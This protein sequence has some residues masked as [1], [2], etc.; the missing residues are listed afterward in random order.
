LTADQASK[1]H[2]KFQEIDVDGSGVID[3][4]EFFAFLSMEKTPFGVQ[5]FS[6]IDENG[7]GEIDFNEFLVGLWNMCTF[8]EE[9]L[10][11]FAFQLIDKD[12]SGYVDNEE[13]VDMVKSVHGSKFDKRLIPHVKKVMSKYDDNGDGQYSFGEFKNCHKD[14]PLL[15]MPA[16]TLKNVME[17]DFFGEGFWKKAKAARKRDLRAQN[18]RDFMQ[19]NKECQRLGH[20]KY[21][22]DGTGPSIQELMK[23]KKKANSKPHWERGGEVDR[24]KMRADDFDKEK[25]KEYTRADKLED[26]YAKEDKT[27]FRR[28]DLDA[29]ERTRDIKREPVVR[30]DRKRYDEN[31]IIKGSKSKQTRQQQKKEYEGPRSGGGSERPKRPQ[32]VSSRSKAQRK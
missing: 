6:L 3:L 5:L 20:P 18:I 27:G 28:F 25:Q 2:Q 17:D 16:F 10:L 7:S 32:K 23:A 22:G 1:L 11:K 15:F 21:S 24:G 29:N 26:R 19:L 13:V 8:D 9:A 14:L 31:D 30:Q 12:G 4:D